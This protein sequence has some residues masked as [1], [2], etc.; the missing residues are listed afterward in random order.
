MGGAE[1]VGRLRK[2]R[3]VLLS[4]SE[5]DIPPG[6]GRGQRLVGPGAVGRQNHARG[7]CVHGV[8]TDRDCR[9]CSQPGHIAL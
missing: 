7:K 1:W 9:D 3:E 5:K 8:S 2:E 4:N 6:W